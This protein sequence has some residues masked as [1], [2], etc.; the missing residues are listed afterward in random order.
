MEEEQESHPT[1]FEIL[2]LMGMVIFRERKVDYVILETG[3]GGRLDATNVVERPLACI[4]TSVSRD[5]TE[6]LGETIPEIAGEKAGIIKPGVPVVYDGHSREA[7]QVI[8]ARARRAWKPGLGSHGGHVRA[9]EQYAR[10]HPLP[11]PRG[12]AIRPRSW[13]SPMWR[14][15]R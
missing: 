5:H 6:Y 14:N 15:T 8:A 9:G 10:G 12:G 7:A 11:V 13:R 3:L 2:F 4:I 1:Y